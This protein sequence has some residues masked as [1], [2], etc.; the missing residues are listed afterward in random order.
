MADLVQICQIT[1]SKLNCQHLISI[2][3]YLPI[4][5]GLT[6]LL[7]IYTAYGRHLQ[8]WGKSVRKYFHCIVIVCIYNHVMCP[9]SSLLSCSS[10][11]IHVIC[12]H[13]PHQSYVLVWDQWY[14]YWDDDFWGVRG[15]YNSVVMFINLIFKML[16]H[17]HSH[18][19]SVIIKNA[20]IRVGAKE[21]TTMLLWSATRSGSLFMTSNNKRLLY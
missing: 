2:L 8:G 16:I 7:R 4:Q 20:L 10:L 13:D 12:S 18:C 11:H 9:S 6:I 5:L 19:E 21:G 15:A 3:E 14:M 1:W 17:H